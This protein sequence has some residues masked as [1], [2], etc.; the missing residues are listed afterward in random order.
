M[1]LS[2]TLI[3]K[4]AAVALALVGTF[5][6]LQP[7]GAIFT[8]G[9][10]SAALNQT[11][12]QTVIGANTDQNRVFDTIGKVVNVLLGLLGI[13]FFLIVLYAGY[14]WMTAQGDTD[15]VGKAQTM[16]TQ[17]VIGVIIILSAYAISN[18]AISQLLTAS[19]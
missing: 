3:P 8:P 13:V 6:L 7:A 2:R 18:F 1:T 10:P 9:A 4:V 11:A 14:L 12:G 5:A 15:K 19:Q 17:G 16:M